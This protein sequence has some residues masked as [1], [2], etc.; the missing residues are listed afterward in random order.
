MHGGRIVGQLSRAQA[1]QERVLELALGHAPA[2]EV[3]A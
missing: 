2:S 1:T 3:A